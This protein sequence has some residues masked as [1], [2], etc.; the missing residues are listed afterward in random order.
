VRCDIIL[1]VLVHTAKTEL[2]TLA[3][4]FGIS[5]ALVLGLSAG[6]YFQYFRR[7]EPSPTH[8]IEGL[9]P[10]IRTALGQ[11][12]EKYR[13]SPESAIKVALR[14]NALWFNLDRAPT[15]GLLG[16]EMLAEELPNFDNVA[17]WRVCL[18]TFAKTIDNTGSLYRRT[19]V[20]FL[21]EI[22]SRYDSKW[23]FAQELGSIAADW[24][25]FAVTLTETASGNNSANLEGL[26]RQIR[27]IAF[28]EEHFW[29]TVLEVVKD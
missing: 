1:L 18:D 7:P 8:W 21:Y 23:I 9:N 14:E 12:L 2:D 15:T 20:K 26:S 27:R 19:F 16:M 10:N 6:L 5:P 13:F 28:R 4:Q 11:R 3:N 24:N 25:K 17:D 22:L 29:G